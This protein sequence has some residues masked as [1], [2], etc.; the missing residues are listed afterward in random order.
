MPSGA[1]LC[2]SSSRGH[3]TQESLRAY[4]ASALN[5][6]G[7]ENLR[8][9]GILWINLTAREEGSSERGSPRSHGKALKGQTPR[10][11]RLVRESDRSEEAETAMGVRNPECGS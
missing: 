7:G 2:D 1:W 8:S 4:D 10:V 3:E 5:C 6:T 11:D 9:R